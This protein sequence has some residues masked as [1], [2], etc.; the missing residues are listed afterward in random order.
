MKE[1]HANHSPM[2]ITQ[3][4]EAKAV[5]L[6]IADYEQDQKTLAMLKMIAR[7]KRHI[8][9]AITTNLSLRKHKYIDW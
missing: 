3:N 9:S 4:G 8:Q 2:V 5:L 1:V 7:A 6:D